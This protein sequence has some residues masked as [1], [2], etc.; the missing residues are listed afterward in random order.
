MLLIQARIAQGL[1][2]RQLANKLELKEQQFQKSESEVYASAN[3][4]RLAEIADILN[5]EITGI[6]KLK[7][8]L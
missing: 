2:Q 8:C 3:I 7:N 5:L 1:T 4:R 6:G